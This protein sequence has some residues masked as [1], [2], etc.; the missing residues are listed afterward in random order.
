MPQ[1]VCTYFTL[2]TLDTVDMSSPVLAAMSFS[3]MGRSS[4]SSPSVKNLRCQ[5]IM[6]R[7]V[8]VRVARRCFMAVM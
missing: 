5:S 2:H 6:A 7:M 4:V 8:A 1:L 3:T